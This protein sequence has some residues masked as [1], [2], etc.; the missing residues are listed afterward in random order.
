[1]SAKKIT[2]RR[3]ALTV[4]SITS[5]LA[6]YFVIVPALFSTAFPALAKLNIMHISVTRE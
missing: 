2:V 3:G 1:M 5:D 6:K 4:Y